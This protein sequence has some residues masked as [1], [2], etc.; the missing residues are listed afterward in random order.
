M[1]M[2]QNPMMMMMVVAGFLM[3][4][5]PYLMVRLS[6]HLVDCY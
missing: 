3:L 4:A 1:G 6:E 2:L 5:T